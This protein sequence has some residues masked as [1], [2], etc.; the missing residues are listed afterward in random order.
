[1]VFAVQMHEPARKAGCNPYLIPPY[2]RGVRRFRSYCAHNFRILDSAC[3]NV[4]PRSQR[5]TLPKWGKSGAAS[6]ARY[7]IHLGYRPTCVE[8]GH[9][10]SWADRSHEPPGPVRRTRDPAATRPF[11]VPA[12]RP[13][14]LDSR[15]HRWS[16]SALPQ[17]G[18]HCL[19]GMNRAA[20]RQ[21]GRP[22]PSRPG[23]PP[24]PLAAGSL[25][26]ARIW[27]P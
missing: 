5:Y 15:Y 9:K 18:P 3:H 13:P 14:A 27:P 7:T 16:G 23:D 26:G 17:P 1:M 20:A 24:G 12:F 21:Q 10:Q 19:V 8:R 22:S 2:K 4:K 11:R 6:G 25:L